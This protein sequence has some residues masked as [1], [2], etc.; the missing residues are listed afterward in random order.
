MGNSLDSF[1]SK[2]CPHTP[3]VVFMGESG[4]GRTTALFKLKLD[5]QVDAFSSIGFNSVQ[6]QI[7][8]H[9]F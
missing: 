2:F 6:L 4:S 3:R 8:D 1:R 5:N 9:V 7:G